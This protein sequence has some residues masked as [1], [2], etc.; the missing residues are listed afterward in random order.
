MKPLSE[1]KSM[2]IFDLLEGNL[3]EEEKA[4][5]LALIHSD[6]NLKK[7]YELL[8]KTFIQKEDDVYFP[9]KETLYI[10]TEKTNRFYL[11]FKPIAVAAVFLIISGIGFYYFRFYN[12]TTINSRITGISTP[13]KPPAAE[14]NKF[15]KAP[16]NTSVIMMDCEKMIQNTPS[17]KPD[18]VIMTFLQKPDNKIL[19]PTAT[20]LSEE[21]L[22]DTTTEEIAFRITFYPQETVPTGSRK[23]RTLYYQLFRTGRTMLA[24]LQLPEVK[25][26]TQK[27]KNRL[28][29]INIQ[30]NTPANYAKYNEN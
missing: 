25:I 12:Q 6:A 13:I 3:S 22:T 23:K 27:S 10:I 29:N 7:E 16:V 4:S 14:K 20:A 19:L 18:T 1:E 15:I 21:K 17:A 5:A 8:K 11:F 26:N 2:L 9:H 28:P 30:I 24:N